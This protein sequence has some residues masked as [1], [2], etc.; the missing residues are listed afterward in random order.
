[1]FDLAWEGELMR[2]SI[3]RHNKV[4]RLARARIETS[5][6]S[7]LRGVPGSPAARGRGLKLRVEEWQHHRIAGRPPHAGAD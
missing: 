3:W 1:M 7:G 6:F 5:A 2:P 4:A